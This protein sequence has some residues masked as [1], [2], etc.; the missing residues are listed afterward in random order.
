MNSD[1]LWCEVNMSN[2]TNMNLSQLRQATKT[3]IIRSIAEYLVANFSK[4]QLIIW[5]LD[6]DRLSDEPIRKYRSD[7][8]IESQI[9]VERNAATGAVIGGRE[10]IWTYY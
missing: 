4:R 9:D 6:A 1:V 2:F 3:D 7:N 5:L 8:Q 10:I